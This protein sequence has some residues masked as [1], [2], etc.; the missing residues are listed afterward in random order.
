MEEDII[1]ELRNILQEVVVPDLKLLVAKIENLQHCI[2]FSK[3]PSR[4]D[5]MRFGLRS[6]PCAAR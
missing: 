4:H 3:R 2:E 5:S 6:R 1:S